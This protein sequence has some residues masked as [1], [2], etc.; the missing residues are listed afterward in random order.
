MIRVF[1]DETGEFRPCAA[2]RHEL[3]S[4]FGL[5]VPELE[6]DSLHRDFSKFVSTLPRSAFVNGEPKGSRMTFD[7]QK[8]LAL[9]LNA[10][11]G[12]MTVPVTF[13]RAMDTQIFSA[14]PKALRA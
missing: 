12:V 6:S 10:H 11:P 13:N 5:I 4:V 2:G 9:M 7:R 3:S 8:S 14:W 1:L